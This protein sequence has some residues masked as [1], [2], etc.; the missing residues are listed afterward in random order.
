MDDIGE[1]YCVHHTLFLDLI[2][3]QYA[4]ILGD[5]CRGPLDREVQCC[6]FHLPFDSEESSD[7]RFHG[8]NVEPCV[9]SLLLPVIVPECLIKL[10]S[11]Q[12]V[13]LVL[14]EE[15]LSLAH[16]ICDD[17]SVLKY[18]LLL[19]PEILLQRWESIQIGIVDLISLFNRDGKVHGYRCTHSSV[20]FVTYRALYPC[21]LMISHSHKLRLCHHPEFSGCGALVS[22]YCLQHY[23]VRLRTLVVEPS[24]HFCVAWLQISISAFLQFTPFFNAHLCAKAHIDSSF[25]SRKT[26]APL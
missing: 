19:V 26:V 10:I 3:Y 24:T 17:V 6:T 18:L 22:F 7:L 20:S 8:V 11:Q 9:I 16:R 13:L 21:T 2:E 1:Q 12:K 25:L 5:G 15:D 14:W 4:C 23:L